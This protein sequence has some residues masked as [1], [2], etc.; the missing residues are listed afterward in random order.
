M[1]KI[2]ILFLDEQQSHNKTDR[3]AELYVDQVMVCF[4]GECNI[5]NGLEPQRIIDEEEYTLEASMEDGVW[6]LRICPDSDLEQT[7]AINHR[8]PGH[9]GVWVSSRK[10][11]SKDDGHLD[12]GFQRLLASLNLIGPVP[13]TA[14]FEVIVSSWV[15][16]TTIRSH[17]ANLPSR[18]LNS[19]ELKKI[20][21]WN[22]SLS[23]GDSNEIDF[24]VP[25]IVDS[26]CVDIELSLPGTAG[27]PRLTCHCGGAPVVV[28]NQLRFKM[29]FSFKN[30]GVI[31]DTHGNQHCRFNLTSTPLDSSQETVLV[32]VSISY[33][34]PDPRFAFSYAAG[35][36]PA[37]VRL[38]RPKIGMVRQ[39]DSGPFLIGGHP[40]E[41]EEVTIEWELVEGDFSGR[42]GLGLV[43]NN[44]N[45]SGTLATCLDEVDHGVGDE[46]TGRLVADLEP[47][48]GRLLR[49]GAT[50]SELRLFMSDPIF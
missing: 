13:Y 9:E 27:E 16:G 40:V 35:T 1:A 19:P 32:R 46:R 10:I 26:V 28:V 6:L 47:V 42:I 14:R 7:E 31:L 20:G 3:V 22:W 21:N 41:S 45:S 8:S 38:L 5:A 33:F 34:V 50:V 4:I 2:H 17:I 12:V 18:E 44:S 43:G 15:H 48:T 39:T 29:F 37:V 49:N 23:D 24:V 25:S 30:A 11:P 36:P